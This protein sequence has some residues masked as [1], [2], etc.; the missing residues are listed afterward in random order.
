MPSRRTY[1]RGSNDV[2]YAGLFVAFGLALLTGLYFLYGKLGTD[3][4]RCR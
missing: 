1:R 4:A 3:V 2:L